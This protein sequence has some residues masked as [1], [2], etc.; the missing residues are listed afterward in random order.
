MLGNLASW[1]GGV[2]KGAGGIGRFVGAAGGGAALAKK[3]KK[4]RAPSWWCIRN[5]YSY[6]QDLV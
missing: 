2:D 1:F 6:L 3:G 5:C 4:G